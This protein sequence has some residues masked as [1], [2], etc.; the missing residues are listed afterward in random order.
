MTQEEFHRRYEQYP[1]D[2]KIELI[3]GVVYVASPMKELHGISTPEL[4]GVFFLYKAATPGVQL[5][6]NMT[7]ILGPKNEPQPDLML[8]LL[9]EYGGQSKYNSDRYLVGAPEL[10]AEVAH[11]TLAID[12]HRKKRDYMEA[13]V[14]E[15]LVYCIEEEEIHWFHF[16]SRGKL[17]P[18]RNGV[19]KSRVFPG[20]WLG[21]PALIARDSARL[22]A[23][24]QQGLATPE[25]AEFVRQLEQRRSRQA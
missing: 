9:T 3:G 23:A 18:D 10:A 12:M 15:Y 7:A 17:K 21:G 2:V 14:Q 6:E 25:H 20:L 5:A 11:S 16:P 19:W 1:D 24:L 8:R 22:I 4:G 13:G